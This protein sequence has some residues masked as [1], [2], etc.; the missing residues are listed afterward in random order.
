MLPEKNFFLFDSSSFLS[1]L[2]FLFSFPRTLVAVK[3][4]LLGAK[5]V[6]LPTVVEK[7]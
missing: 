2:I 3:N 6:I 1:N 5:F 7:L 4:V